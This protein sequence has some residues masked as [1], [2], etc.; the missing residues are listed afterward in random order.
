MSQ[1]Q[2]AA[3]PRRLT[4][5]PLTGRRLPRWAPV[6]VLAAAVAIA[7]ALA[8]LTPVQGVGGTLVVGVLAYLAVQTGWSL[9][10]EGRGTRGVDWRRRCSTARSSRP[11]S[12]SC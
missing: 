8:V 1:T 4:H 3:T 5:D 11:S 10:V 9:A 6:A 2:A 12:R 7:L